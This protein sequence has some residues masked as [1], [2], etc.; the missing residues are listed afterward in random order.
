M[1]FNSYTFLFIFLPIILLGYY[2]VKKLHRPYMISL[3]LILASLVFY[4]W[5]SPVLLVLISLSILINYYLGTMMTKIDSQK[6][7]K[8]VLGSGVSAN[9]LALGYFKYTHFFISNY[10]SLF[11]ANFQLHSIILPL[12]ISFLTLQQIAY[13]VDIYRREEYKP[14][15]LNYCLFIA[16]FPKLLSGP[17]VRIKE[18]MPQLN[19]SYESL[20]LS[21]SLAVGL[22]TFI[23][24]LA[25]KVIIADTIGVYATTVFNAAAQGSSIA[26]FDSWAGALAYTCQLYFDFSG[27]TDMAIGLGL[28]F[29]IRLPLNFYSPYKAK[30]I[31]DFWRRWHITLSTF[32]RDYIYIPMG[33]NR[34]GFMLQG[35]F[36]LLAMA[37][38]GLWHGAGWTFIIWGCLHGFYLVV[39][40]GWRKIKT[41]LGMNGNQTGW[42]FPSMMVTFL[43]VIVA[44]VFFRADSVQV[45]LNILKG[46]AGIHGFAP[47]LYYDTTNSGYLV[48]LL[49]E[50]SSRMDAILPLGGSTISIAMFILISTLLCLIPPNVQ[51]YMSGYQPALNK[52]G[53]AIKPVRYRRLPWGA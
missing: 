3:W 13:L 32:I 45:A 14:D 16:F 46:M 36:L 11:G 17:I 44:W 8:I 35:I 23:L 28:M 40:H 21:E 5:S 7:R 29:G 43:A 6:T 49:G 48:R 34:K 19:K 42:G 24:G 53:T 9:I 27:Y 39:N 26:F 12:G 10:N 38:A 31:I 2:L 25:K 47:Q 50:I 20:S 15:F 37:I 22:T 52:F 51:E 1:L 41:K 4:S 30:S 33:G 18:I